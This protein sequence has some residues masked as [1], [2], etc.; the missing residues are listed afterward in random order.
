[1]TDATKPNVPE[2]VIDAVEQYLL[3]NATTDAVTSDEIE[4]HVDGLQS[5]HDTNPPVREVVQYLVLSGRLAVDGSGNGYTVAT[6]EDQRADAIQSLRDHIGTLNRR[7]QGLKDARLAHECDDDDDETPDAGDCAKCGG[8]IAGA[9]WVW[10]S[11][12]LCQECY[13]NKPAS[14]DKFHEWIEQ[15]AAADA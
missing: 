13:D 6:T 12:D 8:A 7:V 3:E 9:A 2:A 10:Y 14:S 4:A 11:Y 1:M 5:D 15:G